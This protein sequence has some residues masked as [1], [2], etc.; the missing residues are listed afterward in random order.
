MQHARVR[1]RASA[2]A[3]GR[4][5]G[6]TVLTRGGRKQT[7]KAAVGEGK[8]DLL[9]VCDKSNSKIEVRAQPRDVRSPPLTSARAQCYDLG[10]E[11]LAW[12]AV[13]G[14]GRGQVQEPRCAA[15][16]N[17]T[18]V[19]APAAGAPQRSRSRAAQTLVVAENNCER[20][21]APRVQ[22]LRF[23]PGTTDFMFDWQATSRYLRAPVAVA[24]VSHSIM[25]VM[26]NRQTRRRRSSVALKLPMPSTSE[27]LLFSSDDEEDIAFAKDDDMPPTP[28]SAANRGVGF[29]GKSAA[30]SPKVHRPPT[31]RGALLRL[32][33]AKTRP[34]LSLMSPAARSTSSRHSKTSTADTDVERAAV[35]TA[36]RMRL[37]HTS[38]SAHGASRP[39]IDPAFPDHKTL[40]RRYSSSAARVKSTVL[41]GLTICRPCSVLLVLDDCRVLAFSLDDA[42]RSRAESMQLFGVEAFRTVCNPRLFSVVGGRGRQ[43]GEFQD[44][45]GE[46]P[47]LQRE[48]RCPSAH[49][50]ACSAVRVP[51]QGPGGGGGHEEQSGAGARSPARARARRAPHTRGRPDAVARGQPREPDAADP[52]HRRVRRGQPVAAVV[53][54]GGRQVRFAVRGAGAGS[55]SLGAR[56][57]VGAAS[58][59]VSLTHGAAGRQRF[60]LLKDGGLRPV[61]TYS[62]ESCGPGAFFGVT[63]LACGWVGGV[64]KLWVAESGNRWVRELDIGRDDD[65]KGREVPVDYV[66][67]EEVEAVQVYS[68][69]V[70][71]RGVRAARASHAASLARRSRGWV[72]GDNSSSTPHTPDPSSDNATQSLWCVTSTRATPPVSSTRTWRWT[73]P[74]TGSV[75]ASTVSVGGVGS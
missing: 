51:V 72:P 62:R 15:W 42:E 32:R 67:D 8:D 57:R 52:G 17:G 49:P 3:V 56:A 38:S 47:L 64:L 16:I 13:K 29:G 46:T 7:W 33:T 40:N 53:A 26:V 75:G 71:G 28:S 27:E 66:E 18:G 54:G 44:P 21:G 36:R 73:G 30:S 25:H 59:A 9:F 12:S 50:R 39:S 69:M 22:A 5:A 37:A 60:K 61:Q 6:C 2:L 14:P 74:V 1:R 34:G 55:R 35:R 31:V 23:V 20:F 65:W 58:G 70:G 41:H 4:R 10:G 43:L 24:H 68:D 63:S 48:A 19:R 11:K 45:M